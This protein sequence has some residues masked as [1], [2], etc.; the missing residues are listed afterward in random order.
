MIDIDHFKSVNDNYGHETGDEVLKSVVREV[1]HVLRPYDSLG[2]Y[3]GEEFLVLAPNADS[4]CAMM[5]AERIRKQVSEMP[6]PAGRHLVRVS[7]SVGVAS[8]IGVESTTLIRAADKALY[9]SKDAGRNKTTLASLP[10]IQQRL[11]AQGV[12]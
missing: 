10:R 6:I 11:I 9:V 5:I 3:G 7:V 1:R 4:D 12:N 2:R 8:G